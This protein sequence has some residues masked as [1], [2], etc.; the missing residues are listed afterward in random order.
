MPTS[1][2]APLPDTLRVLHPAADEA[3]ISSFSDPVL[4]GRDGSCDLQL[5]DD[6][7]DPCHAEIY[8]VGDTWWVRDLGSTDGTYL[9][10]EYID[11]APLMGPSTLQ[12]GAD[13]P[14]LWLDPRN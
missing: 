4:V 7:I 1:L 2:P 14:T 12:L 11:V 8:R 13:G 5:D 6:R 3:R 10:E 9:D